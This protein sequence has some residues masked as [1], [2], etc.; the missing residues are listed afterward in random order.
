METTTLI[1]HDCKS[2]PP[3]KAGDYLL[4]YFLEDKLY[5]DKAFYYLTKNKWEDEDHHGLYNGYYQPYKWAEI[6]L[7]KEK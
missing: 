5:W 4:S 7:N 2:D 3:Q 1:W 6:N